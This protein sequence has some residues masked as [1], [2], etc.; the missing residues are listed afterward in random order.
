MT[1][2]ETKRPVFFILLGR[3]GSGKGTQADLLEEKFGLEHISTGALLR[4]RAEDRDY[5]GERLHAIIDSGGLVPTPLVF[6]LWMPALERLRDEEGLKGILFDGSP[7]KLYEARMLE[8]VM[9]FYG[10]GEN[11]VALNIDISREEAMRRLLKRGRH[12]DDK[13]DIERRLEWFESEVVPV[14]EFYRS[15]GV[16]LDINGAQ[17]VKD[18]HKEILSKL[19]EV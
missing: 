1:L 2:F 7:R 4:K 16:L 6:Q 14:I 13:D 17:A 12:D 3:P 5:V 10:W 8:E 15:K 9:D 19:K 11:I 18:V